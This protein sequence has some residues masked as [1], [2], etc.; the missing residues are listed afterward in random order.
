LTNDYDSTEEQILKEQSWRWRIENFIKNC[1]FL[2]INALHS[3]E[4]NKIAAMVAMKIFAFDLIACLRKD[5]GGD[6]E[7]KTVESIFEELI[8]F[9]AMIKANGDKIIVTFHGGYDDTHKEAIQKLMKKLDETGMN[10][11]ISWLG[12]RR[13]E[14][15]FK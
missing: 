6:F 11:P 8:E 7:N 10:V 14:V 9:P 5:I 1:D 3:I 2:G 4:L 12:N 13:I 15:R